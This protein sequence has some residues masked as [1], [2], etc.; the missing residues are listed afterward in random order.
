MKKLFIALATGLTLSTSAYA[1][2]AATTHACEIS[3]KEWA[4]SFTLH[5]D[6]A[7]GTARLTGT[8]NVSAGNGVTLQSNNTSD[9][10]TA[11]M[12]LNV[13]NALPDGLSAPAVMVDVDLDESFNL[14][15]GAKEV[16]V[17]VIYHGNH[18]STITCPA[19]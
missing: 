6:T 4:S 1:D 5:R 8:L 15:A 17:K 7:A 16:V 9:D 11:H 14:S 2:S 19:L 18:T 3:D 12:I 13:Y 10:K